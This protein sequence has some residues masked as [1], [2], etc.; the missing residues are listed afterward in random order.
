MRSVVLALVGA[1]T[2]CGGATAGSPDR[3]AF[4]LE[5]L[6]DEDNARGAQAVF[7]RLE[8][9]G[10]STV[11]NLAVAVTGAS[12]ITGLDLLSGRTWTAHHALSQRPRIAGPLVFVTGASEVVALDAETGAERWKQ[13][14][15]GRLVGAGSDGTI[16]ALATE[17]QGQSTLKVLGADGKTSF[18]LSTVMHLGVPAV[19]GGMVFVPWRALYVSAFDATNG[20]LLSSL[21]SPIETAEVYETGGA[22]VAGKD[23]L[24]KLTPELAAKPHVPGTKAAQPAADAPTLTPPEGPAFGRKELVRAPDPLPVQTDAFDSTARVAVPLF[25]DQKGHLSDDRYYVAYYRFVAGYTPEGKL[26]WVRTTQADIVQMHAVRGGVWVV[27]EQGRVLAFEAK[28]GATHAA[29][30]FG[31]KVGS[32][33]MSGEQLGSVQQADGDDGSHHLSDE[34]RA[35]VAFPDARLVPAQLVL[36]G[37]LARE[38]G[39]EVTKLI[40]SLTEDP[41]T[42]P[43]LR[44]AAREALAKR[45]D[46]AGL[47]LERLGIRPSLLTGHKPAPVGPIARAL[48]E[49]SDTRVA[50]ALMD[51]I[52][53]P[54]TYEEDLPDAAETV[55]ARADKTVLPRMREYVQ[56]H[57]ATSG[58]PPLT[59]ALAALAA[60]VVRIDPGAGRSWVA[61]LRQ[62]PNTDD[63]LREMLATAEHPPTKTK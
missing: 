40:L 23:R 27:D 58:S 11:P 1:T 50:T 38:P 52:E 56:I 37:E 15:T 18:E 35:A 60:G 57:H 8:K 32:V 63:E 19:A 39:D 9:A 10:P 31:T 51:R 20:N 48:R 28:D 7:A 49:S 47:L 42:A 2:S 44:R 45:V 26:A 30:R 34:V 13:P 17:R 46:S 55:A 3:G 22:L 59:R 33:T 24:V 36:I 54:A 29:R 12:D 6:H 25:D 5:S 14:I 43:D 41:K 62:D 21:L 16:T 4:T 53:D 61:S